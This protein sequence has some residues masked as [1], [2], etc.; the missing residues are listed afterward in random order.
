MLSLK[1]H[2][3]MDLMSYH[4]AWAADLS[5][6]RC[7]GTVGCYAWHESGRFLYRFAG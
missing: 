1:A 2:R 7:F 4:L 3:K 6:R 5:T